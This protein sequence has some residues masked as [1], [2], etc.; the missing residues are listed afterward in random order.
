MSL[1]IIAIAVGLAYAGLLYLF[2]R[3]QHYGKTLT[4]MLFALRFIVVAVVM[5]LF[6]NPYIKQK[7]SKTEQPIIVFARDESA[8]VT[9]TRDS[10]FYKE[11][12]P[13][14]VD[15]LCNT[16]EKD[17]DIETFEFGG[18]STDISE[19]LN[20]IRR[21][22]YK[23]NVGAVVLFSDGIVNQGVEPEYNT[24]NF[25]FPIYSVTLGDTVNHPDLMIQDVRYNKS[26]TALMSFP[27]RITVNAKN[28][29]GSMM[30][31]TVKMDGAEV[32]NATVPVSS[33][34]F[35]KTLDFNI[36]PD[37]EGIKQIDIQIDGLEKET[38]LLNNSRRIF[39]EVIDKKY[40]VL[41]YAKSPHPDIAAIKSALG[42][43]FE[44]ETI[45]EKENDKN[46][47]GNKYNLLIVHQLPIP[48]EINGID[49][50]ELPALAVI[51]S[52]TDINYF[53]GSQ[54]ALEIKKGA[55]S[56]N[57]DIKTRYNSNFGLFTVNSNIKNELSSY[58][59]LSLPHYET[60]FKAHHDDM[61]FM[62]I[63]DL[64]TPNPLM[65][66]TNDENGRKMA[67]LFGTGCW[68]W[69]LYE[70]YHHKNHDGF[71][72][73]FSKTVKYLLTERSKELTVNHKDRYTNTE[74]VGFTAELRNPSRELVNEP[75]LHIR[76][77]GRQTKKVYDYVFAKGDVN[78]SLNIGV[79][80]E[81][82]YAYTASASLGGLEYS[83]TGSFTVVALGIEA[84]DLTAKTDRMKL[85]AEQTG[86][87]YYYITDIQQLEKDL[88][89][90]TRITSISR[91][92][93][94]FD[95]L[96][97]L[98]WLF[99]SILGLITIEWVLRKVFG[100]Y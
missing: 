89:A 10:V 8:S 7:T 33:N 88:N 12:L 51:G 77:T 94:I 43:H 29:K 23:R 27:L 50:K 28:A 85:I 93:T 15:S 54:N 86:G 48:E 82:V 20:T 70:Y 57:L 42:D 30:A 61:M 35:S 9:M 64:Q 90:D 62:N 4:A 81:G 91:E 36:T 80:P 24:E 63:M 40:N 98:K 2:N 65:S 19:A 92:E 95:D 75:D 39:V 14:I 79:L 49:T 97:N 66:F 31:A 76:I 59:P 5:M 44:F 87:K 96:I 1:I 84:Q 38:Q 71:N 17:Y 58:P 99:F 46:L 100:G 74:S 41:C 53:N 60:A 78:Y 83:A 11:K 56:S 32:G 55:V 25:P 6:F 3:R 72:E 26:V 13:Q 21:H 47:S 73:I 52:S 68:R 18:N 45:F 37:G 34:N 67:V 16:F 69:K 22:Y